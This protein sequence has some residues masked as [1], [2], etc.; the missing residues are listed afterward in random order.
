MFK[1]LCIKSRTSITYLSESLAEVLDI[2][3]PGILGVVISPRDD[4]T[5]LPFVRL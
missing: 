5:K 3:P 4:A 2:P 1:M